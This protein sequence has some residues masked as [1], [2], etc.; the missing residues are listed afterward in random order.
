DL[1]QEAGA[2]AAIQA[3]E[4]I[5]K[6]AVKEWTILSTAKEGGYEPTAPL[7]ITIQ[8][9]LHARPAYHLNCR[10]VPGRGLHIYEISQKSLEPQNETS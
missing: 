6:M 10:E 8:V 3:K 7:H 5:H 9:P 1:L 2:R 4:L